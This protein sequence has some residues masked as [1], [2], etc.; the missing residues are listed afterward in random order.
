MDELKEKIL[1]QL[2]RDLSE[3]YLDDKEVLFDI[4]EDTIEEA[5]SISNRTLTLTNVQLLKPE[6]KKCVKA[7][8]LQR[9]TE[10]T[11]SL[12][13]SG[14]SSSFINAYEELRNN[15]IKGGKRVMP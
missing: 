13:E 2:K 4:L 3:N 12:N 9:G 10:D 15:I 14:K 7:L 5:L 6:I 1:E 11:C 8:Y